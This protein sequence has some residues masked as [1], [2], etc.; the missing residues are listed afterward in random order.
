MKHPDLQIQKKQDDFLEKCS[1]TDKE[2]HSRIFRVGNAAI[3]YHRLA[4]SI[5]DDKTLQLYFEEWLE[6]L[7]INIRKNMK[8][9]GLQKCKTMLPFTRYLNE[10]SDIGMDEWMKNHLCKEDYTHWS[11]NSAKV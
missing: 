9:K 5:N 11:E 6:G 2:F 4:N 10:R 7:P 3:H 1:E 8:E